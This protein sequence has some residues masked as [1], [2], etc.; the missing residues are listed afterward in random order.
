MKV[1]SKII[2]LAAATGMAGSALADNFAGVTWNQTSSN[3]RESSLAQAQMPGVRFDRAIDEADGWGLRVGQD[4]EQTRYY[5]GY[6]HVSDSHPNAGSFR[7]RTLT[8]SYDMLAPLTASSRVFLGGSAG[9]SDIRQD[10]SGFR[11]DSDRGFHAGLQAGV[12]WKVADTT[13]LEA[14]YRYHRHFNTD[15]DFRT[16]AAGKTGTARLHSTDVVYAGL[17]F[18]F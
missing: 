9:I 18:R 5:L 8:A 14:G 3:Y 7:Q 17:N 4:H 2:V 11:G 15:V 13:E 10:T 16:A 6:D 1:L 12:T